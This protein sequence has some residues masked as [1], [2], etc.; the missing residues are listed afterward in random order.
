MVDGAPVLNANVNAVS[1][2]AAG[3]DGTIYFID[4]RK[5]QVWAI[6]PGFPPTLRHVAGNGI[7]LGSPSSDCAP[8]ALPNC[9]DGGDARL[10]DL[11]GPID[12]AV[13]AD[14]TVFIADEYSTHAIRRV[15]PEGMI[16]TYF[17]TKSVGV[18]SISLRS[19]G[20]MFAVKGINPANITRI[21]ANGTV[22]SANV[23]ND[24]GT[25]WCGFSVNFPVIFARPDESFLVNCQTTIIERTPSGSSVRI[26]GSGNLS[27]G[28]ML[29]M[30]ALR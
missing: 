14:G 3:P 5:P 21:E 4:Y 23:V 7:L 18:Q 10:A 12:L 11:D 20:V 2:I 28:G 1:R 29:V 22:R 16:S 17:Y 25:E 30:V 6:V 24:I 13:G 19:D 26:G 9:G 15:G 27:K 8:P